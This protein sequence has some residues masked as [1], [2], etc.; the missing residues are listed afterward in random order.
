MA[1]QIT[2]KLFVPLFVQAH[3]KENIKALRHW[4]LWGEPQVTLGF[5]SVRARNAENVST[6]WRLIHSLIHRYRDWINIGPG[7]GLSTD[8]TK[9]L[10]NIRAL[11]IYSI[12][13]SVVITRS[14]KTCFAYGYDNDW[15]KIYIRDYIH[16]RHL[17]PRGSYGAFCEDLGKNWPSY[18]GTVLYV[19]IWHNHMIVVYYSAIYQ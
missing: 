6:W 9:P 5:P 16:K 18:N 4:S 10:P 1:S 11:K 15:G 12:Q 8:G 19:F 14:N 17:I 2:G 13:S 3:I 7:I